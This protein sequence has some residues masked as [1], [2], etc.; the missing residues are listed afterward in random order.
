MPPSAPSPSHLTT[1]QQG[2]TGLPPKPL[3]QLVTSLQLAPPRRLAQAPTV[4]H[5]C[6]L[7]TPDQSPWIPAC[8]FPTHSLS[9]SQRDRFKMH[10][11]SS[12]TL[13]SILQCFPIVLRMKSENLPMAIQGLHGPLLGSSGLSYINPR[14]TFV[15]L[16]VVF[17]LFSA[18]GPSFLLSL[19][20][21][22]PSLPPLYLIPTRFHIS[23]FPDSQ[24]IGRLLCQNVRWIQH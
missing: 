6:S 24:N 10:I 11:S 9:Y 14:H 19:L 18:W 5:R 1:R 15:L 21:R 16:P 23:A 20:S 12:T 4:A 3:P 22:I 2:S 13:L 17:W 8:P 7:K